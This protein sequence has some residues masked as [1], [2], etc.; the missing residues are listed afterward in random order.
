MSGD[1]SPPGFLARWSRLKRGVAQ[2]PAP[3]EPPPALAAPPEPEPEPALDLSLLPDI[4]SLSV[5][6]DISLFLRKG[7]P[8]GLRNAALKRIWALDPAVR[9]FVGPVDYAWD[10]NAPE[11][12]PGIAERLTGDVSDMLA[13]IIGAPPPAEESPLEVT[14]LPE[15]APPLQAIAVV[16]E[17]PKQPQV[18]VAPDPVAEPRRRHGGARPT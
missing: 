4:G 5:E 2:E 11:G 15:E 16:V 8:A 13:R 6:S 7:V 10:F 1:E 18:V 9:D 17:I 3:P 14:T 12:V